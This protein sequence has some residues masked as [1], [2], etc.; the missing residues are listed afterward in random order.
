MSSPISFN[1]AEIRDCREIKFQLA[2]AHNL[3]GD[4]TIICDGCDHEESFNNSLPEAALWLEQHGWEVWG[5]NLKCRKC[6]HG[7]PMSE[8]QI[9]AGRVDEALA[10]MK[11][12]G[13]L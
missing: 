13:R 6:V 3:A 7:E 9:L 11:D 1:P 12:E 5:T 8:D 10:L 4:Y 2:V